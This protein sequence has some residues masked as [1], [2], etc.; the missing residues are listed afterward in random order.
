[1]MEIIHDD[2]FS[3]T[4]VPDY[5]LD[6]YDSEFYSEGYEG[7]GF[8]GSS[9]GSSDR[10]S[11]ESDYS[12]LLLSINSNLEANTLALD[13]IK[14][15]QGLIMQGQEQLHDDLAHLNDT[16]NLC[17]GLMFCVIVFLLI[18]IA[19]GIFNKTLGL[20]QL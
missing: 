3:T 12:D 7:D 16:I 1:M 2:E 9:D 10:L 20:G 14:T 8:D 5:L 6:N 18:K 13:D 17:T 4:I 15:N 19:F 11:D